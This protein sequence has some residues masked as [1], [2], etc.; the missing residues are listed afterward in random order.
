M[1][2]P[3][4]TEQ[5]QTHSSSHRSKAL[6]QPVD[7]LSAWWTVNARCFNAN[8]VAA[9]REALQ[10]ISIIDEPT[11]RAAAGGDAVA[12]VGLALRLVPGKSSPIAYRLIM[13]A[14]ATCAAEG[15]ITACVVMAFILQ[16]RVAITA[17]HRRLA[18]S[19]AMRAVEIRTQQRPEGTT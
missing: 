15:N 19:W 16:K 5:S 9:M 3:I 11:W 14:L 18:A 12:A 7:P 1:K 17:H 2:R 10:T 6:K 8:L 13:T 4:T